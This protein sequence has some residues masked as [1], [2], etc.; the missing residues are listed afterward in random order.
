M[1]PMTKVLL[2]VVAGAL[3]LAVA[4]PPAEA[5]C[6]VGARPF[7]SIGGAGTDNK[8]RFDPAGTNGVLGAEFGRFWSCANSADGNNFL[9][10]DPQK[11]MGTLCPTQ[12]GTQAGGGWW[13]V[14]Q[15]TLR[16][17]DGLISGTGCFA[18]T[19]P[20]S[21]LCVVVEDWGP[22]G[23]PGVGSTAFF[24]GFRT[25]ATP[26]TLRF[27]DFSRQCG[28]VGSSLQ[29]QASMQQFPVPKITSATKAG[30]AR[31][32]VTDSDTDPAI[33][34]YVHTPNV[35]PASA[36]IESYDLM[37]HY[38]TGDPGR[39][40]NSGAWTP[41]ASIP[42]NDAAVSN[43]PVQV[44]CDQGLNDAYLAF[45]LTFVGGSPG[46]PVPSQMVGRA[47]QVECGGDI[48]EP[49]PKK[50]VRLDDRPGRPTPPRSGR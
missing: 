8:F 9:A 26:A 48:A 37:V 50:S 23:P 31:Q 32:L 3:V 36:L 21:D 30:V 42:Y 35:G 16:G 44:P 49:K 41:L 39:N 2:G 33:N 34:V 22:G 43:L 29:C 10:G 13:Q 6:S 18:S 38:G 45:G 28:A 47:I 1:K 25:L 14:A 5:Q 15:T 20:D 24:V 17:V 19:C 7:A 4:A 46:G 40:R 27:W 11:K 12:G